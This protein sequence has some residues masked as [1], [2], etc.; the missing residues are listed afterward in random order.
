MFKFKATQ[1]PRNEAYLYHVVVTRTAALRSP[2]QADYE[3]IIFIILLY[4]LFVSNNNP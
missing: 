2:P 4:Q 3:A 1:I